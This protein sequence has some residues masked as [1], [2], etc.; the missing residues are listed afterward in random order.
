MLISLRNCGDIQIS[1]TVIIIDLMITFMLLSQ[2]DEPHQTLTSHVLPQRSL[3]ICIYQTL[4][5][6]IK[7]TH[8]PFLALFLQK[9][10]MT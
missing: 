7:S 3:N 8:I 1:L 5:M 9:S 4:V 2:G 10:P 6:Y